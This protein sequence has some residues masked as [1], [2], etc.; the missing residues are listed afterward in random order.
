MERRGSILT[1]ICCATALAS[2]GSNKLDVWDQM[3]IVGSSTAYEYGEAIAEALLIEQPNLKP[4]I[5][6]STGS[7]K[8]I[9]LFCSAN[10][11]TT[12][13]ITFSSRRMKKEEHDT[14]IANGV[15]DTIE[16]QL[17]MDGVVLAQA[18]GGT[19]WNLTTA[20]AYRAIAGYPFGLHNRAKKWNQVNAALPALPIQVYGPGSGSGTRSSFADL[21]MSPACKADVRIKSIK[22]ED[23]IK[24]ICTQFRDDGVY[25]HTD[26]NDDLTLY[27]LKTNKNAIGI[28]PSSLLTEYADE[29]Q[30]LPLNGVS[31]SD[32]TIRD[33]SYVGARSVYVY[34]KRAHLDAVPGLKA[35]IA[36]LQAQSGPDG[37][38]PQSGMIPITDAARAD[39]AAIVKAWRTMDSRG[40]K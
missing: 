18:K 6:E 34:V 16:F 13:D 1:I 27:K 15:K 37:L 12:P 29:L 36:K 20:D 23:S 30:A 31:P 19:A 4:P 26:E 35:Y 33:E 9:D 22:N 32:E 40:L 5:V 8:G 38:L 14:C 39:S 28:I 25:V 7:G 17:G 11:G 10:G 21:I 3:R 24:K 2:C